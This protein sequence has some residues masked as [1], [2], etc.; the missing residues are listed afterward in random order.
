MT[1][2]FYLSANRPR[3]LPVVVGAPD[4]YVKPKAPLSSII[5]LCTQTICLSVCLIVCLSSIPALVVMAARHFFLQMRK[6]VQRETGSDFYWSYYGSEPCKGCSVQ[7]G[8]SCVDE[9]LL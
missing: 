7:Q 2:T 9:V 6:L 1:L 3:P 4:E 8:F 5:S